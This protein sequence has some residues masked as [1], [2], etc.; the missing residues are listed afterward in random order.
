LD[1]ND[2]LL[3]ASSWR[4]SG[5]LWRYSFLIK[6]PQKLLMITDKLRK[7]KIHASNHY[8][9][10]ADLLYGE[11]DHPCTAYVCPRILNLW[12]DENATEDYIARSCD[13]I[14]SACN[15]Q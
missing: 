14:L 12:V 13:I 6:D 7:N 4:E 2:Q 15:E 10:M 11:K 1:G 8:W 5:V 3:L 9:S